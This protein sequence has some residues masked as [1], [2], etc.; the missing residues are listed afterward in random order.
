MKKILIMVI[1]I[2]MLALSACQP[3]PEEQVVIQKDNFENLINETAE[4]ADSSGATPDGN[5]EP[6]QSS[7]PEP[8]NETQPEPE[9]EHITWGN[10]YS[11]EDPGGSTRVVFNVDAYVDTEPKKAS[12]F[13]VDTKDYDLDF[14]QRAVDYFIGDE[15]Y[16]GLYTKEDLLLKILP[17]KQAIQNMSGESDSDRTENYFHTYERQY[18]W[19]PENSSPGNI[20]F[21]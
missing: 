10:E 13:L 7:S 2:L 12:V 15:Y 14:A 18:E 17:F 16:D 5:A 8:D 6:E 20:E 1:V 9:G 19:A 11:K 3:T 21:Q 4:S